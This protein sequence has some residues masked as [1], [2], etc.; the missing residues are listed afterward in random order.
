MDLGFIKKQLTN[1]SNGSEF[2]SILISGRTLFWPISTKFCR[3]HQE[4]I[5]YRLVMRNYGYDVTFRFRFLGRFWQENG[6]CGNTHANRSVASKTQ[7]EIPP[8]GGPIGVFGQ[9]LSRNRV[10][11]IFRPE[12]GGFHE[13]LVVSDRGDQLSDAFGPVKKCCS[14]PKL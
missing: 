1:T 5:F 4:T 2:A 12:P 14:Q 7:P 3:E 13:F 6:C 9:L 8:L 11:K 10:S